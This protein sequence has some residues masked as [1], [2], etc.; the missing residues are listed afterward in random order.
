MEMKK[1]ILNA[2]SFSIYI[3]LILILLYLLSGTYSVPQNQIGVHQ[4]FGKIVNQNVSPGMHYA[5]PWP[6]DRVD[7]VPVKVIKRILID[8]FS[9]NYEGKSIPYVFKQMTGLTP[10]CISGDNN[11][12]NIFCAVQYGISNPAKYLFSVKNNEK[13]LRDVFCNAIIKCLAGLS[14]DEILTFGKK[15]IEN[16]LKTEAQKKLND[17]D[18]GLMISFVELR[19]VQPPV[20][21]QGAFD[22]VINSKIDKR[23]IVSQAES[24]RN[25]KLPQAKAAANKMIQQAQTYK[26]ENIS[27]AQGQTQRFL[28]QLKAY[29]KS[30]EITKKRLY[31]DF[32]KEIF[33]TIEKAY[34]IENADGKNPAN[35]KIFS[36][37]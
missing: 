3:L 30:E 31:L 4:R 23:K 28:D 29:E 33:P 13:L 22:D 1:A 11:I 9:N 8:D 20:V 21:V 7:K 37:K 27:K 35:I 19:N 5:L 10:C 36:G 34:I 14:V 32:I 6:I 2:S 12:V 26:I 15:H 25:E 16:T 17:L 18:C 24:Y